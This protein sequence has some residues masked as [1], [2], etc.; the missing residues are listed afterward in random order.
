MDL[1]RAY[2]P[3]LDLPPWWPYIFAARTWNTEK[4]RG[5]RGRR[6]EAFG[7]IRI[8]RGYLK[9]GQ[10]R[11]YSR[12]CDTFSP[13]RSSL[14]LFFF[15]FFSLPLIHS[16]LPFPFVSSSSAKDTHNRSCRLELH[17]ISTTPTRIFGE[18]IVRRRYQLL[19]SLP[20]FLTKSKKTSYLESVIDPSITRRDCSLERLNSKWMTRRRRRRRRRRGKGGETM[21]RRVESISLLREWR[22][23]K[24]RGYSDRCARCMRPSAFVF[25]VKVPNKLETVFGFELNLEDWTYSSLSGK[26][27]L[28]N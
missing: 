22:L 1:L 21:E 28:V 23:P 9:V 14:F 16:P 19:S 26:C 5:R 8:S 11:I 17:K 24:A 7:L 18:R 27:N 13:I 3:P 12:H 20:S 10:N 25:R 15:L 2:S 4:E 6:G